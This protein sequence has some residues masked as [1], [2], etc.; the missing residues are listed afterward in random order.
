MDAISG[1]LPAVG[2]LTAGVFAL[3]PFVGHGFGRALAG[4][5]ALPL[6]H[7]CQNVEH[8]AARRRAGSICS[9]T[10]MSDHRPARK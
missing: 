2:R 1:E 7:R 4:G 9:L 3:A 6:A 10:D 8:H 5:L